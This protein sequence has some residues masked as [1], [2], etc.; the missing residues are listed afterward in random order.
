MTA[1]SP[2][3]ALD[4]SRWVAS[5]DLAFAIRDG[6]PVTEGHTLVITR[7]VVATFFD[8][9]PEE[10]RAVLELVEVVKRELDERFR[11]DGYN[12]GFNAG[13]AAGQTVMHLHVHVIPRYRGDM[14]DP[15]GGVRHVIP[16]KGN[17]KRLVR[18]LAVGG[19]ADPLLSHLLPLFHRAEQ[20]A[21]V[22]AFVQQSGL[23]RL[24]DAVD[25]AVARGASVRI[26]TGD[27]LNITQAA[28]LEDLVDWAAASAVD[29]PPPS[30]ERS[31]EGEGERGSLEARIIEVAR[32]AGPPRAFH[33]KSWR[34]ESASMGALF[35]GSS[36]ISRSALETGVEWNLRVD[37]DGDAGAFATAVAE[38]ER[39]WAQARV[40]DAAWVADYARRARSS[41]LALPPGEE[42]AD[43]LASPPEPH[44]VQRA[45][46]TELARARERGQRRSLAVLATG[47]GKTWLAA[48]D[49]AAFAEETRRLPRV[50]FLA[51]R[52]EILAQA[53]RTF[54]TML[55]PHA[56]RV[57][58]FVGPGGSL[59][60]DLVFASVQKLARRDALSSLDPRAFDYVIVDEVHHATGSTDTP[61]MANAKGS[62][63]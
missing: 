37:R 61:E 12:V 21:V 41:P 16:H 34:F 25:R 30:L 17:Y 18:S 32:L 7:R 48:F 26:L 38:F 54:R 47:L 35:V 40:L 8:A 62:A 29:D 50:L 5:N 44:A 20:V 60:G 13:E 24:R 11:P 51:H 59:D 15:R 19:D 27:Y 28:A 39:L 36:N 52:R 42:L 1:S 4:R 49:V 53:A 43:P 45:A 57:S 46:L 23:D 63:S 31:G 58:W 6:F 9:T 56:P 2:F 3:L 55:R 33:P 14:N 22:A 10:Q